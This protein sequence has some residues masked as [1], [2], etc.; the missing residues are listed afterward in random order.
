MIDAQRAF[1]A[2]KQRWLNPPPIN[3]NPPL[4]VFNLSI[5]MLIGQLLEQKK[6]S[7]QEASA[8]GNYVANEETVEDVIKL[9]WNQ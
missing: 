5:G 2:I 8:A 9:I 1:L 3:D 7:P 4:H 6:I